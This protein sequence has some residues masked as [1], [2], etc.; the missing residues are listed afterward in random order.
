MLPT[1]RR[2]RA[3]AGA[4]AIAVAV[5]GPALGASA[6]AGGIH[7]SAAAG[8][9][10]SYHGERFE[11]PAAWTVHDLAT[12]PST[13]VRFDRHAV[14]EG[15]AGADPSC[16]SRLFGVT[17][18]V[19]VAPLDQITES[20]A[21][22][23]LTATTI[24]GQAALTGADEAVTHRLVAVFPGAGV[25]ATVSFGTDAAVARQVLASF[26]A[27]PGTPIANRAKAR[28]LTES[29]EIQSTS[30]ASSGPAQSIGA[31]EYTADGFDTCTA[32]SE[33]TMAAWHSSS[34]YRVAGVY[35]GGVNQACSYGYLSAS[36]VAQEIQAGWRLIPLYVG[37]QASCVDQAGLATISTK[38]AGAEGT[39]A[40]EDAVDD[41]KYFAM[42]RTSPIYYDMEA[43]DTDDAACSAAVVTFIEAWSKELKAL[44][45]TPGIY[46]SADAGIAQ[47]IVPLQGKASAPTVLDFAQWDG[48]DNT[49]SDYFPTA[50]WPTTMRIKQY[51]GDVVKSYGGTAMDIDQDA[52]HSVVLGNR[53]TIAVG[54]RVGRG[55]VTISGTTT[56]YAT[57]HL[58]AKYYGSAAY[59]LAGTT[60]AKGGDYSFRPY[61]KKT[62]S[63][64]V[65]VGGLRSNTKAATVTDHVYETLGGGRG[66]V[67]AKVWTSPGI[68][69]QSVTFYRV[70]A[71][72][73]LTKRRRVNTNAAGAVNQTLVVS[74]SSITIVAKLA[75]G[76][77]TDGGASPAHT[78][79]VAH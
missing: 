26:A 63:F 55:D 9:T 36:W 24:G 74:G 70:G 20:Q 31:T 64:Y 42:G 16:P 1:F 18:A 79:A 37:P 49:N 48:D 57:V 53:T 30:T 62:S 40:A 33:A 7:D 54:D 41:A 23:D 17:E 73:T 3:L 56:G 11:V 71:D 12:D 27:E 72:G 46:G 14:Y 77:G 19:Q 45:Y 60:I 39:A 52:V 78:V 50:A 44:G 8:Q 43:W 28:A 66:V 34:P 10:L 38:Q 25:I 47:S 15:Q 69:N 6:S 68:T 5:A 58:Y 65:E 75:G 76:K 35:I 22:P 51:S 29:S 67:H 4:L 13:C 61:V 2:S 32:P 21:G 59:V